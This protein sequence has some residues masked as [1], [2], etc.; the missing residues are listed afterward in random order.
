MQTVLHDAPVRQSPDWHFL[1]QHP[2]YW[3]AFGFGSGLSPVA[4]GTMG[5]LLAFPLYYAIT[6]AHLTPF[7]L[8]MVLLAAQ[9]AGVW[10]CDVTGRA[11]G[12]AD[13]GGIVWDEIAACWLILASIPQQWAWWLAAFVL[14]RLFDIW[15]PWPIRQADRHVKRGL[16]VMLDDVLA[17]V[18]VI[19]ILRGAMMIAAL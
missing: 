13:Y 2:A 8:L 17:A 16:G 9:I 15:K 3:M 19:L 4:P 11:L 10:V 7:W 18:Y 1:R 14:F 5:S 6:L 12:E